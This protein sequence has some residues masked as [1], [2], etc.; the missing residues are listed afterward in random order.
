M[1][2]GTYYLNITLFIFTLCTII[3]R[4]SSIVIALRLRNQILKEPKGTD[5]E[6]SEMG[7]PAAVMLPVPQMLTID[8]IPAE[9]IYY[10]Q[11]IQLV[12]IYVDHV[13]GQ[14]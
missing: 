1:P 3:I 13:N 8:T 14:N 9:Q 10:P 11:E 6:L 4:I 5:V 7:V 2:P 12:P